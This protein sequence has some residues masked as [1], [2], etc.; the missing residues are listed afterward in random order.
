MLLYS[1]KIFLIIPLLALKF[2]IESKSAK[3]IVLKSF[4]E[5]ICSINSIGSEVGDKSADICL[6]S[7]FF[8][9][10]EV[11]TLLFFKSIAG[12]NFI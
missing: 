7:R 2:A 1:S 11:T 9:L 3:Y 10:V 12:I 8:P 5:R 6:Y 4:R